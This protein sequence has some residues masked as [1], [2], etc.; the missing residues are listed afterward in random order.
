MVSDMSQIQKQRDIHNSAF[1][2]GARAHIL[3][4]DELVKYVTKWR[5][6]EAFRRFAD[7]ARDRVTAGTAILFMCAGEGGGASTL[8]DMGFRDVTVSDIS[9]RGVDAAISRDKGLK[10]MV[11][12]AQAADLRDGGYG[13][14]VVQ[15]GLH[16]LPS[17]VHGFTAML[18][19]ATV[20]AIF[21]ESHD[22]LV[23]KL[24]GTKWEKNGE[25]INYAFRWS[26][27]LV[28][29][30][31]CSYLGTEKFS[32]LSF[33]FW[34]HNIVYHHLGDRLGGGKNGVRVISALKT[35]LDILFGR[36]G[37]QFCGMVVLDPRISDV[38]CVDAGPVGDVSKYPGH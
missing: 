36:F 1:E 34:H 14:V 20:A 27:K 30:I 25:V 4:E 19:I 32:N 33:S 7:A 21:L 23:G 3:S 31:V 16:H 18:R 11:L 26:H 38:S 17:P 6:R 24:I 13:I 22:S 10:G 9:E 5:L 28:Y 35:F 8:C 37:N 15:D 2:A 12:N 29:D